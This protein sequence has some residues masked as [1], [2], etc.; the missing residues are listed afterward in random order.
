MQVIRKA[1][2]IVA[3]MINIATS[4][5]NKEIKPVAVITTKDSS[6]IIPADSS[7]QKEY[8][9]IDKNEKLISLMINKVKLDTLLDKITYQKKVKVLSVLKKEWDSNKN[10][11]NY[12]DNNFCLKLK[13]FGK[14]PFTANTILYDGNH[15]I[16]FHDY[17]ITYFNKSVSEDYGFNYGNTLRSPRIIEVCGR[18]FLYSDVEFECNG[19]GCNC[20]ITMIYDLATHVPTFIENYGLYYEG[21]FISDFNNDNKPDLLIIEK[22][23]EDEMKGFNTIEFD[24]NFYAFTYVNGKFI[25]DMDNQYLRPFA[26]QL[27][28]IG[29]Y[30]NYMNLTYSILQNNWFRN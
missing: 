20:V 18:K 6:K 28:S 24:L 26:Y 7:L 16:N 2:L 12:S 25:P 21:F 5:K 23:N 4:C 1:F 11:Y 29:E 17:R 8:D 14:D 9:T 19:K 15:K 13:T 10:I 30:D 27:H 22:V 3:F